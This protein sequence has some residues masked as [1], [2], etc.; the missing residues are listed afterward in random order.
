MSSHF[1]SSKKE[2]DSVGIDIL[3]E[4]VDLAKSKIDE[5]Q[6]LLLEEQEEYA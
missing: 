2:K 5:Y 3:E 1:A 4:Y 6:Y